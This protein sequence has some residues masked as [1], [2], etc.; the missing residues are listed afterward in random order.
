M[1]GLSL[2]LTIVIVA[3]VLLVTAL[4]VMT[5]FGG[6]IAQFIGILNPWSE[7]MLKQS[8]CNQKCAAYC[9]GHVGISEPVSWNTI[10]EIDAQSEPKNCGTIMQDISENC[11]CRGIP[12]AGTGKSEGQSCS[13]TTDTSCAS[14]LTCKPK[15]QGSTEY[16]CQK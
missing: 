8:L 13:G 2:T 3:I 14:P 12:V 9:Q 6:Q 16:T 11:V 7:A 1:K 5:I 10:G 15:T 4:V